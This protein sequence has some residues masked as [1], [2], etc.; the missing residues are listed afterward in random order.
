MSNFL[1]ELLVEEIPSRL[2]AESIQELEKLFVNEFDRLKI[3]YRNVNSFISPRRMVFS[4]DL[5][6]KSTAYQEEKKGPQINAPIEVIEKFLL[7][8]HISRNDCVEKTIDKKTFLFAKIN[9]SAQETSHLLVDIIKKAITNIPWKKSMRWG[10]YSMYF[11][12]PIRNILA[13]FNEK[14]IDFCLDEIG[15]KSS[16]YTVGHRFLSPEKIYI[17]NFDDYT[18]KIKKAFVIIDREERRN[19]IENEIKSIEKTH[20]LQIDTPL[21]LMEEV[22]GLSEYPIVL[23]GKIPDNFMKLPEE[24][25]I[26]P[27]KVHQRYFPVRNNEGKLAPYFVFVANNKTHDNGKIIIK[28]NERV[29]NARLSDALFFFEM[30]LKKPLEHHLESLK[31]IEFYESLG[32]LYER[33]QR[34]IDFCIFAY[35]ELKKSNSWIKPEMKDLLVRTATLAKCDLSTNIVSEFT[36]LQ[37]IMGACY[38]QIQKESPLVCNAIKEQYKHGEDFSSA[39]SALFSLIDKI[40]IIT[41]LF[42]I[43]KE[44]TGSKDPFALRRAAISIIKIIKKYNIEIDLITFI[45]Q[46]LS[47]LPINNYSKEIAEKIINFIKERLKILLKNENIDSDIINSL[48]YNYDNILLIYQKAEFLNNVLQTDIGQRLMICYKRAKNIIGHNKDIQINQLLISEKEE[49]SLYNEI[50]KLDNTIK[51]IELSTDDIKIKFE[52]EINALLPIEKFISIFFEKILV[53]TENPEIKQNRLNLI[54]KTVHLFNKI[55]PT[56]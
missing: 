16:N 24:V 20:N 52:K 38:A 32:S 4:S 17:K 7:A 54:T 34:M 6:L 46:A 48:L 9:H 33:T 50:N 11:V 21:D 45:K 39:F 8:Y 15:V 44:P 49:I 22:V 12:R 25:I 27:M 19:I 5:E 42:A 55:L 26:T 37:G 23:M 53:N 1:L 30:D 35:N 3:P 51:N 28:G 47:K 41:S 29:L 31:K 36:E 13:I 40:E 43:G 14:T 10:S 56:N 2:Q 18:Y